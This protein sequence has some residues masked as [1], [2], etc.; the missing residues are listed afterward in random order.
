MAALDELARNYGSS[1]ILCTATQPALDKKNFP[2]PEPVHASASGV[3]GRKGVEALD[4]EGRELAPDPDRLA[5][6]LRRVTVTIEPEL[7]SDTALIRALKAH[8]QSLVIVNSRKHALCLYEAAKQELD[9]LVHLT[10]RQHGVHRQEI[11]R[12][13]RNRLKDGG[14]CRLIATSLIE[15]GVDIDFPRVWRAETG[16]DQ[17]A[18]A[19][20]R[21]NREGL[22]PVND[23]V[24]TVF[25]SPDHK[26]PPE[27]EQ[28]AQAFSRLDAPPEDLL[29]PAVIRRYFCELYWQKGVEQLDEKMIL[30][31]FSASGKNLVFN[32]STAAENFRM[33]ENTLRSV[34]ISGCDAVDGVLRQL[35]NPKASAGKSARLLQP[36][37]VQIPHRSFVEL[38]GSCQV[39]YHR[40]DLW[41]EQF[42]VLADHSLYTKEKGLIW[43]SAGVLQET[44]F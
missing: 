31:Q 19:A 44:I 24:V 10:T 5:K 7:L 32:Y 40:P 42:A 41:G 11:L 36:Y 28:F 29:S 8:P 30:G 4:L 34:I 21:C 17:I 14:P 16:L 3:K 25:T 22:N 35:N 18:Q 13:V 37:I 39:T 6:K 26:A 33:I 9:A 2:P 15:A 43:E 27:I 1:I 12:D 23:S 38:I 20:G